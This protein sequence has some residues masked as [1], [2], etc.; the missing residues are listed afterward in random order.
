MKKK[1]LIVKLS[2]LGDVLHTTPLIESVASKYDV[3]FL[4]FKQ[5]YQL[6]Y[7]LF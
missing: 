3:Y 6:V 5:N 4:T 1:L 7:L 2:S